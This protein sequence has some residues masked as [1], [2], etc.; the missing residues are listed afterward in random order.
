LS[1]TCVIRSRIQRDINSDVYI[2]WSKIP[3]SFQIL[4]RLE[5]PKLSVKI[6]KI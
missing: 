3:P 2:S 5:F 4:T 6:K 1:E